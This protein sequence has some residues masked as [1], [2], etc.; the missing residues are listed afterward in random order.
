VEVNRSYREPVQGG[1]IGIKLLLKSLGYEEGTYE[2]SEKALAEIF[3]EIS[4]S[5]PELEIRIAYKG[6]YLN[7]RVLKG[8]REK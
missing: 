1:V 4:N 5:K 6:D 7:V 8:D 3:A 2:V